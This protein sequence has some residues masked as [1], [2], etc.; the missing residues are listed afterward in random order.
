MSKVANLKKVKPAP[1]VQETAGPPLVNPAPGREMQLLMEKI[2]QLTA[3]L[4]A[5]EEKLAVLEGREKMLTEKERE[6]DRRLLELAD[7]K[8]EQENEHIR[9]MAAMEE[10]RRAEEEEHALR[11]AEL[12]QMKAGCEEEYRSRLAGFQ[13]EMKERGEEIRKYLELEFRE[14]EENLVKRE[15]EVTVR[16]TVVAEKEKF[17]STMYDAVV[18]LTRVVSAC[19]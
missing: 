5:A 14:K 1:Q 15:G 16:E 9:R 19:K 4:K 13:S 12:E 8:K 7:L 17:W 6:I 11:L 10:K 2:S 18:K 3:Q